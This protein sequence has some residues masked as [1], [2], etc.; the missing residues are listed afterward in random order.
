MRSFVEKLRMRIAVRDSNAFR[1]VAAKVFV[2]SYR[3][4]IFAFA[5]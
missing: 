4:N 2:E 3:I 1:K 5:R